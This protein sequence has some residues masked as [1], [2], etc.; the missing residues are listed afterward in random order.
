MNF[1]DE[2]ESHGL[3]VRSRY[4]QKKSSK[5]NRWET[6][7]YYNVDS[8]NGKES[9][10]LFTDHYPYNAGY[11]C[12][13]NTGTLVNP[14]DINLIKRDIPK[15]NIIEFTC[16]TVES[17]TKEEN[18][19]FTFLSTLRTDKEVG[20]KFNIR[21]VK[22]GYL[23]NAT[24]FPYIN[25]QGI[26]TTGKIIKYDP[27]TGKR[28]KDGFSSNWLHAYKPIL[29]DLKH[30]NK[31]S[32]GV[33]CFFGENLL[34]SI[35]YPVII[36]ESEKTATI[37][38]LLFPN[39]DFLATGGLHFFKKQA[40]NLR[41]ELKMRDVY[42]YA[43][44]LV[45]Q[46]IDVCDEYGF[47]YVEVL[48]VLS[49]DFDSINEG[50]DVA[51]FIIPMLTN[52]YDDENEYIF[53]YI[54]DS[55]ISI[56]NGTNDFNKSLLESDDLRF[57]FNDYRSDNVA[58][59]IPVDLA[60]G[61]NVAYSWDNSRQIGGK[62]RAYKYF[63]IYDNKF[64][65]ITAN[66]DI[67]SGHWSSTYKTKINY[68]ESTLIAELQRIF[69]ILQVL[70]DGRD[71]EQ[72]VKKI[73]R[74]VLCNINYTSAY[75]FNYELVFS[76]Y[77]NWLNQYESNKAQMVRSIKIALD[78]KGDN[79]ILKKRA[80]SR[81]KDVKLEVPKGHDSDE[82]FMD[83]LKQEQKYN[84]V[85]K[86]LQDDALDILMNDSLM[87]IFPED[88]TLYRKTSQEI[89]NLIKEYNT[90]L[91]GG[92]T[93][94]HLKNYVEVKEYIDSLFEQ[95]QSMCRNHAPLYIYSNMRGHQMCTRFQNSEYYPKKKDIYTNTFIKNRRAIKTIYYALMRDSKK[96][97]ELRKKI[98]YIIENPHTI[99]TDKQLFN[100]KS[101]LVIKLNFTDI[102][103]P[104][105]KSTDD[106]IRDYIDTVKLSDIVW[107]NMRCDA[108]IKS[109]TKETGGFDTDW[110]A[111]EIPM[112]EM[113]NK[114]KRNK[115][116]NQNR[117]TTKLSPRLRHIYDE[118]YDI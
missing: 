9:I 40:K 25:Y 115:M 3:R 48:D 38:S 63:E 60:S 33:S 55:I 110:F 114:Y 59:T 78:V 111:K 7:G 10:V 19:F 81:I 100:K 83:A 22:N 85:A 32:N 90:E 49:E 57:K 73:F 66:T 51:D 88:V 11:N 75:K 15:E 1:K 112:E 23:E 101:K 4:V 54:Y 42:V 96:V 36:V 8:A 27:T 106:L 84:A 98:L 31:G 86:M 17:V 18:H 118:F 68:T 92:H 61:E 56:E 65:Y 30:D 50:D 74:E 45:T 95:Y 6:C 37:L 58:M 99:E 82:V 117:P 20:N 87:P 109:W 108:H 12:S 64:D 102:D 76:E 14:K 104:A 107:D 52:N 89:Y 47:K 70:N 103:K 62:K 116:I 79:L 5:T 34:R 53:N 105:L 71:V 94:P 44:C 2:I 29:S 16:K 91:T 24:L 13:T 21:G 77:D 41:D 26:Y 113:R 72:S 69:I 97:N 46:W 35:A 28:L 39:I 43:D 93:T 80:W 67:N